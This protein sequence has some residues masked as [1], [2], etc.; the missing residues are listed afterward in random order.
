M[1]RI[2]FVSKYKKIEIKIDKYIIT[3]KGESYVFTAMGNKMPN[4]KIIDI[5]SYRYSIVICT[6]VM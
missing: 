4:R 1:Q 5:H 2:E 3:L 6:V